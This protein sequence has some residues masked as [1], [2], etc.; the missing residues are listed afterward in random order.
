MYE[1]RGI[2]GVNDVD[3][4]KS[5]ILIAW[6]ASISGR[7]IASTA[8]IRQYGAPA[9]DR[10]QCTRAEGILILTALKAQLEKENGL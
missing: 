10:R 4:L 3:L 8:Y 2:D 1:I 7:L 5:G 9:W 6:R